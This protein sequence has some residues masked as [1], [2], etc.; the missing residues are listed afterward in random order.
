M[1]HSRLTVL[2]VLFA[3][4]LSACSSKPS[5]KDPKNSEGSSESGTGTTVVL[6][7]KSTEPPEFS[8]A[9]AEDLDNM[10]PPELAEAEEISDAE[11][12]VDSEEIN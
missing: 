12:I 7:N 3:L 6:A 11:E 1:K 5:G 10:V 4:I 2:V 9:E 8:E